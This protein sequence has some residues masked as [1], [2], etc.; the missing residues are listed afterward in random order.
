MASCASANPD[1]WLDDFDVN[2]WNPIDKNP[3]HKPTFLVE[4]GR[5]F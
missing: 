4:S 3:T 2:F 5:T 1:T